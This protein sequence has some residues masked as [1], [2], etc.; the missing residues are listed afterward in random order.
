MKKTLSTIFLIIITISSATCSVFSEANPAQI[1]D[2]S[3]GYYFET[4]IEEDTI[5]TSLKFSTS[6]KST[7]K[8]KSKTTYYKN[9]N[10]QVMWYVKVIGTFEY[11]NGHAN[12]LKAS[13]SAHSKHPSWSVHNKFATK[14]KNT[15]SATATGR[16]HCC[17]R[18]V[19]TINK[20][21]TLKCSPSGKF[22]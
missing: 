9:H 14:N 10:G 13:V 2:D 20:T 18:V 12:C 22:S 17:G 16:H 6:S 3:D 21:V 1:C 7:V 5:E 8:T 19:K 4:V 11:G 15:A